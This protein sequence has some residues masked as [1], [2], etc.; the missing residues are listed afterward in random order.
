MSKSKYKCLIKRKIKEKA[1][2][3]L[4]DKK[5]HRNGKGN[6][7]QY[8]S[9]KMQGYLISKDMDILNQEYIFQLRTKMH[10]K[11]KSHFRH[12]H[13]DSLCDGCRIDESTMN[14]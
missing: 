5:N 10:F 9:L 13:L 1:L 11:I 14:V 4:L 3:Y 8:T 6:K 7:I 2:K 12:M